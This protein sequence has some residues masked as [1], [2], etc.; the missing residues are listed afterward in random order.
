M[1]WQ[2]AW[3]LSRKTLLS[4]ESHPCEERY[5]SRKTILHPKRKTGIPL[6]AACSLPRVHCRVFIGHPKKSREGNHR[7]SSGMVSQP[8]EKSRHP[9]LRTASPMLS[10]PVLCHHVSYTVTPACAR[11]PRFIFSLSELPY[12]LH[13]PGELISRKRVASIDYSSFICM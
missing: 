6:I 5:L 2:P 1:V 10:Y 8:K 11:S 13:A 7:N 9:A 12:S 3:Y 4:M